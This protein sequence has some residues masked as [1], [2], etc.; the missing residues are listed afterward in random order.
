MGKTLLIVDDSP[1]MRKIL[2]FLFRTA[3]YKV[4]EAVDGMDALFQLKN[5]PVDLVITDLYMPN[6]NG[7]GLVRTLKADPVLRSLPVIFLTVE[8][9]DSRIQEGKDAG[10]AGWVVKPFRVDLLRKIVG[11]C[12]E[13]GRQWRTVTELESTL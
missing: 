9:A 5:H 10:A 8:A 7:I 11:R 1:S 2:G 6:L 3:G 4:R 13:K 12:L